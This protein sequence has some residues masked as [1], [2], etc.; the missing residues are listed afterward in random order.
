MAPWPTPEEFVATP[1]PGE[2]F[3]TLCDVLEAVRREKSTAK[4]SQRA[5]VELLA[6][7]GPAEWLDDVRAGQGDLRAAGGVR[8]FE[9]TEAADV[10]IIVSLAQA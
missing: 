3:A 10:A 1:V 2:V 5:E 9:L 4:V 6:L 7:S 8:E